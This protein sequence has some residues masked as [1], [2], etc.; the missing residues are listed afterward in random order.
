MGN[1]SGTRRRVA[2]LAIAGVT[3]V[4]S[5]AAVLAHTTGSSAVAFSPANPSTALSPTADLAQRRAAALEADAG[6]IDNQI[7]AAGLSA[8]TARSREQAASIKAEADRLRNL[9][10]FA[11]P[12]EGGVSSGFGMRM[13]P[14][15]RYSRLH[16][17]ADIGGDCGNP[18]YAAQSG[19][20]TKAGYNGGAG[21]NIRI[22]H[23]TIDGEDVETGY[24]HLSRL[25]AEVGDKVVKG[26]LI[27][28]VG[29]TG[30]STAC[31]LHLAL[32]EDGAGSN[33]LEYLTK[34]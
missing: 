15:L 8:R 27:G 34:H 17:G 31:H 4:L 29:N 16:N 21:N 18:V 22:D 20:V 25:D 11:W 13:H 26:E 12:T 19:T 30:L 5:M 32:Y 3:A 24:L 14:I 7:S 10:S 1:G 28:L 2:S 23:G 9:K 33:P 6:Q